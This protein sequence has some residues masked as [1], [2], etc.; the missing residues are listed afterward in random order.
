MPPYHTFSYSR[1]YTLKNNAS[2]EIDII[3]QLLLDLGLSELETETYTT[4]LSS[5]TQTEPISSPQRC[6]SHYDTSALKRLEELGLVIMSKTEQGDESVSLNDPRIISRAMYSR[7]LWTL[8]PSEAFISDLSELQ[9]A[10]LKSYCEK[11]AELER[12]V[13]YIH[14]LVI[15]SQDVIMIPASRISEHLSQCL[16]QANDMICGITIPQWAP[17]ISVIWETLKDRIGA[18]VKYYRLADET[19]FISFGH[20]INYRDVIKVGVDLRLLRREAF[21]EKFFVVDKR[22]AMIFW[23]VAPN[24]IFPLEASETRMPLFVNRCQK[25]FDYLWQQAIPAKE[26]FPYMEQIRERFISECERK[27]GSDIRRTSELLFDYGKY[28]YQR[29]G[30]LNYGI[31]PLHIENLRAY[32]LIVP[33]TSEPWSFV[34]NLMNEIHIILPESR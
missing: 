33:C 31:P 27:F 9:R 2:Q 25:E 26:L 34:P 3:S 29:D 32:G 28:C 20:A 11:C 16:K 17:N 6:L 1:K 5:V 23:P 19:T 8:C 22:T 12:L 21:K 30:T 13:A 18:A 10:E 4:V 14:P 24:D 15:P 7:Y